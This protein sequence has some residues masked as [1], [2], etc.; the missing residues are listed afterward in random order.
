[1]TIGIAAH[2]PKAG[3]AVFRA[4][5]AAEA[6]GRGA[7][8]GFACYAAIGADATLYCEQT[9]RGGASTLF[10]AGET[11][12]VTPPPAVAAA[13]MAALISSGPERPEPLSQFLAADP[14]AG[15]VT[16]HRLP[17][18]PGHDGQ[19][20][21]LAVLERLRAGENSRM[22]V[23]SVLADYPQADVGFIAVDRGGGLYRCNSP[24]VARRPDLGGAGRADPARGIAVEVL[25]NAITPFPVLA[26]LVAQIAF[27]TM[28]EDSRPDGWITLVSGIPVLHGSEHA[29][30]CDAGGEAVRVTTTDALMIQ[31]RQVG[32]AVYL[33]SAVYREGELLG[34]TCFEPIITVVDGII[35]TMSGQQRLQMSYQAPVREN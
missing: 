23:E 20:L 35:E 16:G 13:T 31:G 30:H 1:M 4:L 12:G 15:L 28:L 9:Q 34:H 6:V 11:T 21:N 18:R 32:A 19:P 14:H 10:I 33:H 5:Q 2:G 29:V 22:A 27:E 3:L 24:R 8:G 17:N 26:E 7:I 25:H